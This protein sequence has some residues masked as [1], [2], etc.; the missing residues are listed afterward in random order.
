M[1]F[2]DFSLVGGEKVSE[3]LASDFEKF[4]LALE[5]FYQEETNLTELKAELSKILLMNTENQPSVIWKLCNSFG[6]PYL[7]HSHAAS[8]HR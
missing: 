4:K 6:F 1:S 8:F 2:K 5:K 3:V 7:I